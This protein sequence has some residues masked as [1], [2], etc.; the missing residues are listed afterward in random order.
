MHRRWLVVGLIVGALSFALPALA[1]GTDWYAVNVTYSAGQTLA[2]AYDTCSN[3]PGWI[4]G[5][6]FDKGSGAYG[7]AMFIDNTGYNWHRTTS[8]YGTLVAF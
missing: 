2:S 5:S 8:G 3:Y 1:N 4:D 7:T 6:A